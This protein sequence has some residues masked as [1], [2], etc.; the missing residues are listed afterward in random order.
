MKR[1]ALAIKSDDNVATALRDL[2]SGETATVGIDERTATVV[3]V[4]DVAFGH[5]FAI[6]AIAA[7]QS[8]VKYGE[9]IG[10]ATAPIPAGGHAHVQNI[11][12]LRGRGDL[13]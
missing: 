7:G 12:S 4:D 2:R 5:K 1:D 11:E 8:I 10:R 6:N 3:M 13:G 9:I